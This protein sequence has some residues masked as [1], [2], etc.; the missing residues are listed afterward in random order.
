MGRIADAARWRGR[1]REVEEAIDS[2]YHASSN[3]EAWTDGDLAVK[4]VRGSEERS[5]N[6]S[7]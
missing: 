4:I 1:V 2:R 5:V 6:V 7:A 3:P